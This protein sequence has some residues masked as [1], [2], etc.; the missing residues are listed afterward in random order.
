MQAWETQDQT[1]TWPVAAPLERCAELL[2][3]RL[4]PCLRWRP[5]WS[6]ICGL[7]LA[8]LF[9]LGSLEFVGPFEPP[10]WKPADT[11]VPLAYISWS[12]C[13]WRLVSACWSPPDSAPARSAVLI[14]SGS[15]RE[16]HRVESLSEAFRCAPVARGAGRQ[17]S[18]RHG[19]LPGYSH[20]RVSG[21][22]LPRGGPSPLRGSPAGDLRRGVSL[23]DWLRERTKRCGRDPPHPPSATKWAGSMNPSG[24]LARRT[25]MTVEA[26][27]D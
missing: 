24:R 5:M 13:C 23:I 19:T 11:P 10:G 2:W 21:H 7:L 6:R 26:Q 25:W 3:L 16:G 9:V 8:P 14:A 15:G 1:L 17:R 18:G 27:P 20:S 22:F 4:P 12:L